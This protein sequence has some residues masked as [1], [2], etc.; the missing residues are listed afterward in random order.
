MVGEGSGGGL[1][2]SLSLVG[3]WC[4]CGERIFCLSP[5]TETVSGSDTN[6]RSAERGFPPKKSSLPHVV[7]QNQRSTVNGMREK[8]MPTTRL[9]RIVKKD[10]TIAPQSARGN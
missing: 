9:S 7:V 1:W 8:A 4:W 10:C 5:L 3:C 2:L 6:H